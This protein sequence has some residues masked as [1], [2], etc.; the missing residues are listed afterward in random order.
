[1]MITKIL[2]PLVSFSL[3]FGHVY[4]KRF[5]EE[6]WI[7]GVGTLQFTEKKPHS[8]FASQSLIIDF[9]ILEVSRKR[10][11][12]MSKLE[13][14]HS[15]CPGT[16]SICPFFVSYSGRTSWHQKNC[17][18]VKEVPVQTAKCQGGQFTN[19]QCKLEI[20]SGTGTVCVFLIT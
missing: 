2:L 9:W 17:V 8:V 14:V 3:T 6:S 15:W 12:Q 18:Y 5:W 7:V 20:N 1:M 16:L 13:A 11:G 10:V 4:M 19:L